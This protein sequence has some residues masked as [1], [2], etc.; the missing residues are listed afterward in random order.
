MCC[1][2]GFFTLVENSRNKIET[3]TVF[4]LL[5]LSLTLTLMVSYGTAGGT[6]KEWGCLLSSD[7]QTSF[8]AI[9][10]ST[11]ISSRKTLLLLALR[12]MVWH[13]IFFLTSIH[14]CWPDVSFSGLSSVHTWPLHFTHFKAPNL[15]PSTILIHGFLSSYC[16]ILQKQGSEPSSR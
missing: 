14:C 13:T 12:V 9:W 16:L 6:T 8:W 4:L 15:N 7:K 1:N 10:I 11:V 2:S 5:F 3:V